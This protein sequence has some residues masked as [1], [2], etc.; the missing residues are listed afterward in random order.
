MNQGPCLLSFLTRCCICLST[1]LWL[2]WLFIAALGLSLVATP[3]FSAQ[4]SRHVA[5]LGFS[6]HSVQA[7]EL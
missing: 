1:Y 3:G 2:C 6:S 5:S 4:A 7:Q